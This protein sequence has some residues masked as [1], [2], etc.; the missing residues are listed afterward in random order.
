MN[1]AQRMAKNP[2]DNMSID[3]NPQQ[4]E[5]AW[6]QSVVVRSSSRYTA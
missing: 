3:A 2:R 5:A 4:Q 6:P 1:G